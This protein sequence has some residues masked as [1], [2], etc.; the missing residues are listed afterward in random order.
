VIPRRPRSRLAGSGEPAWFSGVRAAGN[1]EAEITLAPGRASLGDLEVD[2]EEYAGDGLV[3]ARRLRLADLALPGGSPQRVTVA[4]PTL[5][6]GLQR[7]LRL[8]DRA[9]RLLDTCDAT[10]FLSHARH[11]D[12]ACR[13]TADGVVVASSDWP[14]DP[15]DGWTSL[16]NGHVLMVAGDTLRT[17]I[18][19]LP[20]RREA[21]PERLASGS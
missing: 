12:L 17:T 8:Y 4:L 11:F 6:P 14:Q 21:P 16:P 10:A 15:R 20:A 1:V 2:L 5:G 18:E 13:P 7:Q 9:G 3:Q 19:P